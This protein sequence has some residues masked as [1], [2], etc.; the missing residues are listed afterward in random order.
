MTKKVRWFFGIL[1]IAAI[2]GTGWFIFFPHSSADIVTTDT[3]KR[4]DVVQ[5][6]E[7]TGDARSMD[8]VD[9]A[10]SR[11]GTVGSVLVKVGDT[12]S[13]GDVLASLD[14]AELDAA[15]AQALGAVREAEA[16]LA[17]KQTGITS[18]Q[19][20]VGEADV[21]VAKAALDAARSSSEHAK[22]VA[23][24]A[25]A[26]AE[27]DLSAVTS[28]TTDD[29]DQTL[30]DL[31][32]SMRS[33]VADVRSGLGDADTILGVENSL[34]NTAFR[35]VLSNEDAQA[36]INATAAYETSAKSRDAAED[37]LLAMDSADAVSVRTVEDLVQ[38]S[39]T[40][41]YEALLDTSKV[42]DAT[43][44]DSAE[45]S[46]DDLKT[47]KATISGA[48][49]GLVADGAALTNAGQAYDD[50]VRAAS[51]DVQAASDALVS[52]KA[53][54][55]RD[56]AAAESAVSSREADVERAEASLAQLV[57][58][59][60][61]VD[62]DAYEAA[63]AQARANADAAGARLEETEIIA[64][65]GGIVTA[66]SAD[67]GESAV[68]GAAVVTV[69]SEGTNFEIALDIPEADVAKTKVGQP[70]SI[71]FDAFGDNVTFAGSLYSIDP[72][73]KLIEGVVFYEAKV[74]LADGQDL[75]G[76]KPGMSANVTITTGKRD[77]VLS[78]PSRA[79]LER[80]GAKYVRIPSGDTFMERGVSAGLRG[81]G[82]VV[83]ITSGLT[84]GETVIVSIRK[85]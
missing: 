54:R 39:Y 31:V 10:F 34:F 58:A 15:Y 47:F 68:A 67:P 23:Y 18:E 2:G 25:V 85:P 24:A 3:V 11:S 32:E 83:E 55:D 49:S 40:D 16:N 43:S 64:P 62:L 48:L 76:V 42:L 69:L 37:A 74:V 44:A 13:V 61:G 78:I 59:P 36:L 21:E 4:A 60:R 41:A 51:N 66:V 30:Q 56:L 14:A 28:Q 73:Q 7:V 75:T 77:G 6:V 72:A 33:T 29:Q 80:D 65:I 20:A 17:L 22:A 1:V 53:A 81:D 12:V 63:V 82:G 35:G 52:A 57:A 45:L 46:I 26:S 71:T 79:V 38:E 19:R 84:E 8:D 70:A 50:A 9:L 5:T 27:S